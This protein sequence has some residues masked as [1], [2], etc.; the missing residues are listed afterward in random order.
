MVNIRPARP[1]EL[2]AAIALWVEANGEIGVSATGHHENLQI[3]ANRDDAALLVTEESGSLVGMLLCLQGRTDDGL[4]DVILALTHLTGLA[5]LPNLQRVGI[6]QE[7]VEAA[8]KEA[9]RTGRNRVT[10]WTREENDVARRLFDRCGFL[11]TGRRGADER[12]AITL[13][14]ERAI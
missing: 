7:L 9:R 3:W 12:G 14:F 1:E 13:H 8:I 2:D 5:V 11:P 6:G 10:L 4:G